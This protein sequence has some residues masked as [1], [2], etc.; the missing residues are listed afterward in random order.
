MN[1]YIAPILTI[2]IVASLA[3]VLYIRANVD[4]SISNTDE[5]AASETE[6][7]V[8]S[9]YVYFLVRDGADDASVFAYDVAKGT[10]VD[11]SSYDGG[12]RKR[13]NQSADACEPY[14][15][16]SLTVFDCRIDEQGVLTMRVRDVSDSNSIARTMT[17]DPRTLG[18][19]PSAV[20]GYLTPIAVSDDKSTIY[21]GRRVETE[22][23]VAGLWK[24][25]V[26]TG[27][28]SEVAYVREN[29]LYQ[30]EVNQATG[31]LIGTSF[32]PPEG[33]GEPPTGPSTIEL[34]DLVTGDARVLD[35][36]TKRVF[37]NALLS[38]D[39]TLYSAQVYLLPTDRRSIPETAVTDVVTG[40]R[41]A[42]FDGVV[43]DWFGD[44]MVV[45]R[46]GNLFL[47]DL[48]TKAETQITHET[49]A[50]VQYLGVA[51]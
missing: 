28:V 41:V 43:R 45:D 20:E 49:D 29:N 6:G 30:Y 18:I 25:D 27:K 50:T 2:A 34:V 4:G 31:Q 39:G 7:A 9:A 11:A 24:L 14:P 19:T 40:E 44:T 26:A 13:S 48:T 51:K 5:T 22:S 36:R 3:G 16:T 35:E 47:Y 8:S 12:F 42:E 37:E 38:D 10:T 17:V 23:W 33:L 15:G 32:T 1:K 21:L 46:D